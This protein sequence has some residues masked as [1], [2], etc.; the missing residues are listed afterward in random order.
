MSTDYTQLWDRIGELKRRLLLV[1]LSSGFLW[2]AFAAA[3]ITIAGA[4]ADAAF[5]LS[6][7][8][9]VMVL[10]AS[11]LLATVVV[12]RFCS[13]ARRMTGIPAMARFMDHVLDAQGEI[14]A[15]VDLMTSPSRGSQTTITL[16]HLA[17]VRAQTLSAKQLPAA[18]VERRTVVRALSALG[19]PFAVFV[20]VSLFIPGLTHTTWLR[21]SD[22]FGDHPPYSRTLLS[23]SSGQ[24]RVMYGGQLDVTA[25]ATGVP[26]DRVDL[27]VRWKRGGSEESIPMF[28]EPH[29]RWRTTLANV[30]E[31]GEFFARARSSRSRR[32]PIDV[33][34]VPKIEG[35]T[36]RITP[37]SYTNVTPYEGTLPAE[38]IVGLP[39]TLVDF[40]VTSNRPLSQGIATIANDKSL[41]TIK[42]NQGA[43]RNQVGGR[44]S[45][46]RPGRLLI[47]VMDVEGTQSQ[48]A[49]ESSI[50]VLADH[51][52]IIRIVEPPA[53]S[54][55][56]P[57]VTLPVVIDAEDDYGIARVQL[58]RSLNES[59]PL[60]AI[61]PTPTP[62]TPR[63]TGSML[64]PLVRYG[65]QPG[66]VIK[67]FGRVEDTDPAGSKGGES[68]VAVIQIISEAEFERLAFTRRGMEVLQS[69][70]ESARRRMEAIADELEKLGKE[71]AK[72]P[73]NQELTESL[74][75]QMENLSEKM[76]QEAEAIKNSA[77]RDLPVEIDKEL[78][79]EL[80]KL[81]KEL[82]K[83]SADAKKTANMKRMTNKQAK[84]SL[85][86]LR[87]RIATQSQNFEQEAMMPLEQ[88]A[89][90][91][92]LKLDE[93][94]FVAL[95]QRQRNLSER[96]VALKG[97]DG[98]TDP[99]V[100]RRISDLQAEQEEIRRALGDL[101]QDIEDHAQQLPETDEFKKLRASA[102]QFAQRVRECGAADEM[103]NAET[104]LAELS[105]TRGY[106][107]ALA[108][109]NAMEKLLSK[110]QGMGDQAG[111]CL[112]FNPN[113][114]SCMN[115]SVSQLLAMSGMGPA[116]ANGYSMNQNT[117]SNVGL[118][119]NLP[120]IESGRTN[121][122]ED[123]PGGS[124]RGTGGRMADSGSTAT[125]GR[126]N[127][128]TAAG[129]DVESVPTQY[130]RRVGQYF[131]RLAEEVDDRRRP[132]GRGSK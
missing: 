41:D 89:K 26:V 73:D 83:A 113:L 55:A 37:P 75:K 79:R 2:A 19:I 109:A 28:P 50:M 116:G 39:E 35:I 61:I 107:G 119:G 117:P 131:Q 112:K 69:K 95:Y 51:R 98:T 88:L 18:A 120:Q 104:G 38:G 32:S 92:P 100:K 47:H 42:L 9:R 78:K 11:G 67:L 127:S 85:D 10:V 82:A 49:F 97:I 5:D 110:C 24:T 12:A 121:G 125:P 63:H 21:F 87:K 62:S 30:T 7:P 129:S 105:G 57:N 103:S 8:A 65:L 20:L 3:C 17:I 130:R 16:A 123:S 1:C 31:Q 14:A 4:W 128:V 90:A 111:Q 56:T 6:S 13:S 124:W 23:V 15:G 71:I 102:L 45:I 74:R 54:L 114:S 132:T 43:E 86:E 93:S 64:L 22:P 72:S 27:I 52:P 108:A 34:L 91:Y 68:E 25:T 76:S 80:E 101:V 33:I 58:F 40:I 66:D 36:W 94:R 84:E 48:E 60:A 59:R 46:R 106:A 70:Y 115:T 118:Y 44:F 99:A 77:Q 126:N 81:A 96:M 29:G 53:M 122:R